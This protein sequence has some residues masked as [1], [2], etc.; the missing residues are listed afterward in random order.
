MKFGGSGITKE[1]FEWIKSS[2]KLGD[3][4]VEIGAGEISTQYLCNL[5]NLYSIEN[6]IKWCGKYNSNYIYAPIKNG[7]YDREL[8]ASGL[9]ENY[10]LLIIDGPTGEGQRE[11]VIKNIDLF[12]TDSPIVVDDT[13]RKGEKLLAKKLSDLLNMDVIEFERFSVLN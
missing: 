3:T 1:L 8:V 7:W 10:S 4:V 6:N 2:I 9:P 13:H 11:G 12:R 5:Y